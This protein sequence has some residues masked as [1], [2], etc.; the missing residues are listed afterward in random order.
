MFFSLTDRRVES[1]RAPS[2]AWPANGAGAR[3]EGNRERNLR[4]P[5]T[6]YTY[7]TQ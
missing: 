1:Q 7:P 5:S 4:D 2:G 6:P 3:A